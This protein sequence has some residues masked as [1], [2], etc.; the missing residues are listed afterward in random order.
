MCEEKGH[1]QCMSCMKRMT[2]TREIAG[3]ERALYTMG[4]DFQWK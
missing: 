2:A 4:N 1:G 3:K